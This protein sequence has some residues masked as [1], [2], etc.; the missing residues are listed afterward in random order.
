MD[1]LDAFF[2]HWRSIPRAGL[3]PALS[4]YLDRPKPDIQPFS[5][6][7]DLGPHGMPVRLFGTGLTELLGL[8]ATGF[9][10]T[11]AVRPSRR[12][13]VLERDAMCATHP[14]GLR[15]TLE[16]VSGNGRAYTTTVL[17]LPLLR[18]PG[19]YSLVRVSDISN[20]QTGPAA[21]EPIHISHYADAQWVDIGAGVP[22]TP[23]WS[24]GLAD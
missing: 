15:V 2:A 3:I 18:G 11:Q 21:A 20:Y 16:A 24:E 14:C 17:M 6:I 7:V 12:A 22:A 5:M 13:Q 19:V 10:Y 9:D 1:R 23:P 8:D 4:D